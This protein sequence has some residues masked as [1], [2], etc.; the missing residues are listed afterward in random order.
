MG[1]RILV[2]GGDRRQTYLANRLKVLGSVE[3]LAVPGHPD[4]AGEG[5]VD[6][7]ILP[8]PSFDSRGLLRAGEGL[9]MS[10]LLSRVGPKTVC[11]GGAL[12]DKRELL[13]SA[14]QNT[15]DLLAEPV[16][17]AENGRLTAEAAVTLTQLQTED[18]LRGKGCLILG[19][20]RIG[21]PLS[22]LLQAMGAKVTVA[23]RRRE[24]QA[25]A[26]SLGL[27]SLGLSAVSGPFDLVFNTVPTPVLT[28]GQVTGLGAE[29]LWVE[30][31]SAPGGLDPKEAGVRL[32]PAGGLPGKLTPKAAAE[33]LYQGIVRSVEV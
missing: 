21:K 20:G 15:V 23:V 25:E 3:T 30:L 11:F 14:L 32:L 16:V 1:K 9:S 19:W 12:T 13:P 7:L 31:A 29:C 18:S 2:V 17:A 22:R 33:V 5:V 6:L 26:E 28:A 8:C 24:V 10:E 4:S 27:R